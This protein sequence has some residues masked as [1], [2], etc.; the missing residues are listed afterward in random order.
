MA[1][2][3]AAAVCCRKDPSGHL[4]FLLVRNRADGQW[5]FPNGTVELWEGFGHMAA[6]REAWE[7]AGVQGISHPFKLGQ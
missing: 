7:E 2:R 4:E 3:K 6:A 1:S 5:I